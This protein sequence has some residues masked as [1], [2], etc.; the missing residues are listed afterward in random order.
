[1]TDHCTTRR[2]RSGPSAPLRWLL[3]HGYIE[4]GHVTLD[5]GCGYGRDVAYLLDAFDSQTFVAGFDP[6][7]Q[8]EALIG[9]VATVDE[10]WLDEQMDL[11]P[12]LWDNILLTYVLNVLP[13]EEQQEVMSKL[14]KRIAWG[15]GRIYATVRRDLFPAG[16]GASI[17]TSRGYQCDVDMDALCK[18]M[19]K[20]WLRCESIRHLKGRYEIFHLYKKTRTST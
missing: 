9:R 4:Q 17:V 1:M 12:A 2:A 19:N 14:V 16:S 13:L 6:F 3:E 15:G 7:A 11:R 5:Y 8:P 10:A 20:P 18:A